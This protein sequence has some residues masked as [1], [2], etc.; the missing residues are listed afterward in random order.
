MLLQ[1]R[2]DLRRCD[3]V[4]CYV[5]FKPTLA[6]HVFF[7]HSKGSKPCAI[8]LYGNVTGYL[9]FPVSCTYPKMRQ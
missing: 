7:E 9:T 2:N 6:V 5:H 1:K 4:F 3:I 8:P